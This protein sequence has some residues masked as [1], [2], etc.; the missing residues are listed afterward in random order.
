MKNIIK[1]I[2]KVVMLMA[3]FFVQPS[4]IDLEED[5]SSVLSMENLTG[6]GDVVAAL[7]PIYRTMHVLLRHPCNGGKTTF[8][9]DDR[10][11]WW[12]G[13]KAPFRVYDRFDYG[14]GEN[15]DLR[16]LD[17]VW[18]DYWKVIYFANNLIDGLKTAT[19][20]EDV[21]TIAD[22]EARFLRA[23]AYF[24]LVRTFGNMPV[25]LD[26]YTPTGEEQRA[27]V[28]V[29]YEHMEDDL[30]TAEA[31]LPAPNAVEAPGRASSG[32]AKSLLAELYLNWG[33]WPL[34]D[35]SKLTLAANK[36][37]EVIDMNYYELLPIDQLWLL[38]Y[39]N[40]LESVFSL[41]C[42]ESENIYNAWTVGTA[43]HE[44]RGWSDMYPELQFFF[45]FPEG[46]R[47]DITFFTDIPQ[48]G[49]SEGQIF[50]QDPP[51]LPWQESQ[52]VHPMYKKYHLSVNLNMGGRISGFRAIEVIRYAEVLL[53]FA[54]AQAR[55]GENAE[56]IEALNQVK[57]RAAG[58]PYDVPDGTVDV[59][60]ATPNEIVD[61]KGWE[62]AGEY[63]RW[64]DLIRSEM[65]EEVTLRRSPDE[66]VDLVR[67]P[68]KAQY[69]SPIPYEAISTSN[70]EQ[71]PEGFIIQ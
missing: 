36:A 7:A 15:S 2:L 13:N 23:M 28:L 39:Q 54:E 16:G 68:T 42:S 6:E 11:T 35:A 26:G 31:S 27:T 29:N 18:N 49:F 56:S 62:L 38:S 32:A 8:G 45:D 46:P 41:Q 20:P 34:L 24:H 66:N 48:Y 47:K 55:V 59:T 70:L 4:C 40:S 64:Y 69:I 51:T 71:N 67:Q 53:I 22:G 14:S 57:R 21:V 10:T 60:T 61:E 52:R 9:A 37:K 1:H 58:L 50:I 17:G 65:L 25:I 63:K 43:F 33:G 44:S 30:L 5:I 3:M 19:A 12:A